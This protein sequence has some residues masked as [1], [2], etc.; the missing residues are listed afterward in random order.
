MN[1]PQLWGYE[2]GTAG[3]SRRSDGCCWGFVFVALGGGRGC[4]AQGAGNSTVC[5]K[6]NMKA[7]G[8]SSAVLLGPFTELRGARGIAA[9]RSRTGSGPAGF[10]RSRCCVSESFNT[11][12]IKQVPRSLPLAGVLHLW[13]PSLPPG[14]VCCRARRRWAPIRSGVVPN[15]GICGL[16]GPAS[17]TWGEFSTPPPSTRLCLVQPFHPHHVHYRLGFSGG[18]YC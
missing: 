5:C 9:G 17:G 1:S 16:A 11:A 2:L 4:L 14:V 13:F 12:A 6:R 15:R 10:A 8:S 7:K 18:S 3:G